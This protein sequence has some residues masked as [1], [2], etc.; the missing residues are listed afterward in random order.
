MIIFYTAITI[1]LL[2][3]SV[4][5]AEYEQVDWE[6]LKIYSHQDWSMWAPIV[7]KAPKYPKKAKRKEIEGCVNV[8]FDIRSDGT[9]GVAKVFKSIPEGI[10]DEISL[11]SLAEFKY[12][13]SEHNSKKEPILTHNIFTFTLE[14]SKSTRE[15]WI[16][17]C[18]Q[19]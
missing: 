12:V 4:L 7:K 14:G 9:I 6:S 8:Y 13:A 1:I 15:G 11:E 2:S 19:I 16:K 17:K 10:F 18:T 3:G 5:A